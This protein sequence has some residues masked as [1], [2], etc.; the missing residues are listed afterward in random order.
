VA[1]PLVG[2][3][4]A[5]A[6]GCLLWLPARPNLRDLLL[7]G[8][9]LAS[10]L[11]TGIMILAGLLGQLNRVVILSALVAVLA[12][13]AFA[14]RARIGAFAQETR[15]FYRLRSRP[16]LAPLP[17]FLLLAF[18]VCALLVL[19]LGIALPP[20]DWDGL[21]QNLPMAVFHTQTGHIFPTGT[22]YR[23]I[24]AYPQ[25]GA[26]LLAF[27][28]VLE[29]AD[30]FA[31][32]V[33]FPFW[34][35]GGL[36]VFTLARQ[37]GA[38]RSNALLG[39]ALFAAAPVAILQAR[40]AY[41]DLAIAALALAALAL[42]L[43]RR[44]FYVQRALVAGGAAGLLSGLKYAGLIYVALLAALLLGAGLAE[45][46]PKGE[47]LRGVAGFAAITVALGA[48]WYF[49]NWRAF[50]NPFWPMELKTGSLIVFP[51]SGRPRASMSTRCRPRLP[52]CRRSQRSSQSG[53]SPSPPTRRTCVW[54]GWVRCGSRS[55]RSARSPSSR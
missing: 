20:T 39:A 16:V 19:F 31:D 5:F 17:A 8:S 24:R 38:N 35:L 45:R 54:P 30:V 55:A 33:Q 4:L 26:L 3:L 12:V 36:A 18:A 42:V 41:F 37:L 46:R 23:G 27:N 52:A 47:L 53:A 32:L 2:L 11:V 6:A 14:S 9:I 34:L 48:I 10:A 28:L 25:G 7:G 21:A 13:S 15:E 50:G 22:P 29:Q 1:L 49:F 43:N 51:G 40:S 44:L